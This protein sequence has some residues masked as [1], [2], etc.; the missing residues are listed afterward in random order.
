[1]RRFNLTL[2]SFAMVL[3]SIACNTVSKEVS[4][5]KNEKR[6]TETSVKTTKKVESK[7][8]P[9]STVDKSDLED[10]LYAKI[11]T[12]KGEI[13]I[14]LEFDKT[15]VTVANFVGLSEGVIENSAKEK[16]VHYYDGLKFHR[17]IANFM[18][19]G[20]DPLGT[21]SGDPGYKFQDEF[22]PDLR[23]D[24]AGILSMANSGPNT[25]GSQFFITH[26]PT[27]HLNGKHTVFGHVVSGQEVVDA[28]RQGD[29]MNSVEIIRVGKAAKAFDASAVFNE[30]AIKK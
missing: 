23:H 16:G 4:E 30:G 26:G 13:L 8:T 14:M 28:V 11:S 5:T 29:L 20:G 19:Q 6:E 1:M 7:T 15:P 3:S 12:D 10:G 21:G 2:L 24:K 9:M 27:P 22:A 17:V 25:N 18:I